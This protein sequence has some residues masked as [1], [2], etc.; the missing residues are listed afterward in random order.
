M[1]S[2]N[3]NAIIEKSRLNEYELDCSDDILYAEIE[4]W[5]I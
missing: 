3:S 2:L 5:F 1:I 4:H